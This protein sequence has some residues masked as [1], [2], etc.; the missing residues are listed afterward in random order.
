M[1]AAARRGSTT[2]ADR[3]VRR[4]A[5]QAA[6]EALADRPAARPATGAASV[7]GGRARVALAVTLPYPAPLGE[8][9]RGVQ[10]HVAG[11]TRELTGLD[12]SVPRITVTALEPAAVR[13]RAPA[14]SAAPP[15]GRAP[16]RVWSTRGVPVALQAAVATA[17]C[18]ALALDLVLVHVGHRPAAAWRVAAVHW[19]A[20][21]R[22]GDPSVVAL[23]ALAALLGLWAVV[24]AVTPGLRGRSTVCAPAPRVVASVDRPAVEALVRDAVG[25]VPGIGAV[26]VRA[27]RRVRVRVTL[28]YGDRARA[29]AD[30]VAA[31]EEALASCALRR[32]RAVRARVTPA[33]AWRPPEPS[34]VAPEP[35]PAPSPDAV[36]EGGL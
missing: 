32:H 18:A 7:R 16:R 25:A 27:R 19:L 14:A 35:V 28:S 12:L 4:I 9:V 5:E 23:G 30:V 13:D 24:L 36:L 1:T 15:E 21:H 22:P 17:A 11:R 20:G 31:A 26:R 29:R 8:T 34:P 6:G 10:R 3:V 33:A 2:V